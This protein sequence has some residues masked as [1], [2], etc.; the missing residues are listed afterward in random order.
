MVSFIKFIVNSDE[1]M[2][3]EGNQIPVHNFILC[4]ITVPVPVSLRQ[5]LPVPTVPVPQHCHKYLQHA[6][7]AAGPG[8]AALLSPDGQR[9][10][11]RGHHQEKLTR[12]RIQV[13]RP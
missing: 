10:H 13:K 5:K 8:T 12:P 6:V 3:N 1:K 2:L 7:V 9:Q 4:L 11:L